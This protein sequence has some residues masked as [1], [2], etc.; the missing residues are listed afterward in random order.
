MPGGEGVVGNR[1]SG[2]GNA[3]GESGQP[4]GKDRDTGAENAPGESGHG[5]VGEPEDPWASRRAAMRGHIARARSFQS[6]IDRAVVRNAAELAG[7]EGLT[8]ARVSQLLRLLKLAP[9]V[10]A[11][12]EEVEGTGPVPTEAALRKLAGMKT[13]ERQLAQYQ[14][15]CGAEA[16][17]RAPRPGATRGRPPQRG[18]Q[19][20]FERARRYHAAMDAGEYRSLEDLGRAEGVTGRRIAHLLQLLQ[21]D[22]EI[23]E[24]VDVPADQLPNGVT[25]RRLREVA[26]QRG[27]EAQLAAWA[28]LVGP[29]I[30]GLSNDRQR[31]Q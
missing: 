27:R 16:A 8:R 14:A 7:L 30:R 19:H 15:L 31:A 29:G 28:A 18:L 11:D 10:L 20:L 26:K 22:L 25:E 24:A 4:A 12:L 2:L 23:I 3:P 5:F 21:L 17:L 13:P 1:D 6:R 9:G